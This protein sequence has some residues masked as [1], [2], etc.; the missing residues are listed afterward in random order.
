MTVKYVTR[1]RLLWSAVAA[2]AALVLA[3]AAIIVV[4]QV[5]GNSQRKNAS[6]SPIPGVRTDLLDKAKADPNCP[7]EKPA[8]SPRLCAG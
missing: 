1:R 6:I 7:D 5:A 2:L 8:P 4:R 3:A